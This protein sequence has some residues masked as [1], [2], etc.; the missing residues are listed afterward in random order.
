MASRKRGMRKKIA[1]LRQIISWGILASHRLYLVCYI[2]DKVIDA[3]V[4][5]IHT[6]QTASEVKVARKTRQNTGLKVSNKTSVLE[7]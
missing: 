1:E 5:C 7:S 6:V 4:D 3:C 2:N